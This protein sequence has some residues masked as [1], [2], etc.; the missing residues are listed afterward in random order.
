MSEK[1]VKIPYIISALKGLNAKEFKRFLQF[2]STDYFNHNRNYVAF[3]ELL[4]KHI[5]N[6]LN[7]KLEKENLYKLLHKNTKFN[8]LKLRHSISEYKKLLNEF[9]IVDYSKKNDPL[10]AKILLYILRNKNLKYNYS[11]VSNKIDKTK[12]SRK[13]NLIDPTLERYFLLKEEYDFAHH[14]TRIS[15]DKIETLVSSLD[16]YFVLENLKLACEDWINA[17]NTYKHDYFKQKINTLLNIYPEYNLQ[18]DSLFELYYTLFNIL[19]NNDLESFDDFMPLMD[20][21][22]KKLTSNERKNLLLILISYSIRQSNLGSSAMGQKA[23]ELYLVGLKNKVLLDN[24]QITRYTYRNVISMLCVYKRYDE[25][26]KFLEFYKAFLPEQDRENTYQYN[27]GS[28]YFTQ[29]NYDKTMEV[30]AK[31]DFIDQFDK[32]RANGYLLI[33]YYEKKE[34]IALQS[35]LNSFERF[36]KRK[37]N[38]GTLKEPYLKMIGFFRRLMSLKAKDKTK[39]KQLYKEISSIGQLPAKSWLESKLVLMLNKK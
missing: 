19:Y 4:H 32:L 38:L 27:L 28:I 14:D 13:S 16:Q 7:Y 11:N 15:K 31:T 10:K 29:G 18:K 33:C 30:L 37:R 20:K 34:S 9:L 5:K 39:I 2:L 21:F 17:Q 22:D 36:I 26:T 6:N 12:S 8:D 35:L 1:S 24:G 25:S 23:L 3:T